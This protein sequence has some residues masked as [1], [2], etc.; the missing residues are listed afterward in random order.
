MDVDA[1]VRPSRLKRGRNME[2][3]LAKALGCEPSLR[4]MCGK[5]TLG[6]AHPDEFRFLAILWRVVHPWLRGGKITVEP[7]GEKPVTMI[8]KT[9]KSESEAGAGPCAAGE[10]QQ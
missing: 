1:S 2:E 8:F 4:E 5:L 9:E 10:P 3:K 7:A 6:A